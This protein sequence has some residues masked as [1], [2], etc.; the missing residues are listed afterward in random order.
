MKFIL[1]TLV[2]ISNLLF[3]QTPT[4]NILGGNDTTICGDISLNLTCDLDTI[5]YST[6]SYSISSI[7]HNPYPYTIGTLYNIAIDDRWSQIINLP[8]NFCFFGQQFNQYVIGTNG[9]ISFNLAYANL[10]CPWPV[11]N[12]IPNNN[13]NPTPGFPRSMIGL[14]HDID[15]SISG[16]VRYGITGTSPYRKLVISFF[17][18]S[19]YNCPLLTST[20]Q[21]VLHEFTNII[22]I[23]VLRKQIC[24]SWNGGRACLGIQNTAG[25]NA[26][27]PINRNTSTYSITTPESWRFTPNGSI[28]L[29]QWFVNGAFV[30]NGYTLNGNYTSPTVIETRYLYQCP[31][32]QISNTLN[33]N[34]LPCCDPIEINIHTN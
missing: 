31:I 32:F 1:G 7:P 13:P 3:S 9:I 8:F 26:Y 22:D 29:P 18:V 14:Y 34:E 17:Q 28:N 2:L 27:F 12:T 10:Y 5:T 19:H 25:T 4:I 11:V 16:E 21:I 30:G 33:I 15:P 20:F 23:H 6:T 24:G